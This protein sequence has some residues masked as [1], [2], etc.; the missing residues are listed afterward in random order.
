MS[1]RLSESGTVEFKKSTA[2]LKEAAISIAA[3]LNKH[4]SGKVLIGVKDDGT[5]VGQEIGQTTIKD[6][7]IKTVRSYVLRA[8]EAGRIN[9]K[10]TSALDTLKRL[11][12]LS[13]KKLLNAGEVLFSTPEMVKHDDSITIPELASQAGLSKPGIKKHLKQ[14]KQ[15]GFIKRVGSSKGGHWEV[16]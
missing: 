11:G 7:G 2:E 3:I 6:I 4:G 9:F 8:N 10:Y 5:V 15:L 12:L 1:A 13:G 16:L 14:L